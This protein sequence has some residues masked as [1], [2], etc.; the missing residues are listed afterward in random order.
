[1]QI[2]VA[3]VLDFDL[4]A[5]IL[6]SKIPYVEFKTDSQLVAAMVANKLPNKAHYPLVRHGAWS[7]FEHCWKRNPSERPD[8]QRLSDYLD[9]KYGPD[10]S[11]SARP[12]RTRG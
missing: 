12:T 11:R 7:A 9:D 10:S 2:V 8:V 6:S 1:L 4:G 3:Q 5:Q